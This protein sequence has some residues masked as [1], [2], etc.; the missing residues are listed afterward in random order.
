MD[1]EL[2]S[3]RR[4]LKDHPDD[5]FLVEKLANTLNRLGRGWSN[6]PLPDGF[7][8]SQHRVY[9]YRDIEF[10]YVDK[11]YITRYPAMINNLPITYISLSGASAYCRVLGL[12]LPTQQQQLVATYGDGKVPCPCPCK[13]HTPDGHAEWVIANDGPPYYKWCNC[14]GTGY[15][16]RK[17]PWGNNAPGR[18]HI[19][20]RSHP[21]SVQ[22]LTVNGEPARPDGA[23]PCGAHDTIGHVYQMT[24]DGSMLGG[25]YRQML[26]MSMGVSHNSTSPDVGFRMVKNEEAR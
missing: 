1:A 5:S 15:V 11:F 23:S 17:Y 6:Q 2:Q 26:P 8:C 7:T 16:K 14:A 10:V 13:L 4:K 19:V 12:C 22:P 21:R 18:E 24:S 9:L 25:S 20:F 3:L